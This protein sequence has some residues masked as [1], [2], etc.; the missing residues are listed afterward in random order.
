MAVLEMRQ[1]HLLALKKDRKAILELLQRRGVVEVQKEQETDDAF[2][3]M[4]TSSALGIFEKNARAAREAL[5][6]LQ[7]YVPE[8]KSML[9]SLEGKPQVSYDSYLNVVDRQEAIMASAR[10]LQALSKQLSENHADVLKRTN[11]LESLEPW[12]ALDVPMNFMGT[13]KTAAFIGTLPGSRSR[14]EIYDTLAGEA[15]ELEALDVELISGDGEQ[16]YVCLICPKKDAGTLEEALRVCGFARPAQVGGMVPRDREVYL[17]KKLVALEKEKQRLIGEI[18]GFASEREDLELVADYYS[19]RIA[20][21]EVLGELLQSRSTF[22]L[23]GFVPAKCAGDLERELNEKFSLALELTEVPEEEE[24]PV[25]LQ[26]TTFVSSYEGVV[27]AFGLPGKGEID[28]TTVMSFC[29]TFLFGLMLSDAAYGLLIFLAC[30]AALMKFPRMGEGLKKSLRMFMY[31]G[32]STMFWGV[33]F[34]SYFGDVVDVVS[35]TFFGREVTIAPL[36]FV[37]LQ[38]PMKM[39][40]F[41]MLFGVIHL[42][43]GLGMKGYMLLRDKKYLDF[44][45]DVGFW[46][47]FLI[48]LILMLLPTEMFRSI[49]RVEFVFPAWL[50]V[51]TKVA[52]IG[53]ALGILL[54]SGRRK[55]NNWLLRLALGAYDLYNVTGWLSDVL[56]YSRLLALGLAT[57]VIASVIN[58]MGSMLGNGVIGAIGFILVFL[59]GHTLNLGINL[60]GAYVHTNRLQYVEF[61]GKFYEGGGRPFEPFHMKTNYVEIK[62]E[63]S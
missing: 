32:L 45:C 50:Q 22:S 56:S 14:E 26:N 15:P 41:S 5:E 29:Y 33:M 40:M 38:A 36:W 16:T 55:K 59:V 25:F 9:A 27:E 60:L 17:K 28:P 47:L 52:A 44:V 21:Y 37:P 10:R 58:S 34:G 7:V 61:F 13:K 49:S 31:C 51:F 11:Q 6:I 53:G 23:K 2:Q 20:K 24:S 62:E 18:E 42:F 35:R 30:F 39:L 4:D 48:G 3:K 46:F 1:L 43:L 54:M 19:S 63:H 57:G 8:K 12:K